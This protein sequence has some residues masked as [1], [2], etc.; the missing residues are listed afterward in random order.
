MRLSRIIYLNMSK[1][2]LQIIIKNLRNR[3]CRLSGSREVL[4]KVLASANQPLSAIEIIHSHEIKRAQINR[5]TVYRALSFFEKEGLVE[6][7]R[8]DGDERLYHLNLHHHH[9]LVC[10]VCKNIFIV[11]SCE[12][13]HQDELK[14][15]KMTGFKIQRHVLEFYG[16]CKDCAR[17]NN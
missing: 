6:V 4:L 2:E 7:L 14:I 16:L 11:D 9:H 13:L 10:T 8:L 1:Q 15:Q 17:K 3:G 5:A 12:H